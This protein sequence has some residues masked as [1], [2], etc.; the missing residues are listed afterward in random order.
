MGDTLLT[1]T[2]AFRYLGCSRY[3]T[4]KQLIDQRYVRGVWKKGRFYARPEDWLEGYNRWRAERGM[5]PRVPSGEPEVSMRE[6]AE[7]L[8]VPP[9]IMKLLI[10]EGYVQTK[11]TQVS[12][13]SAPLS[14]WRLGYAMYLRD[15]GYD[16][17][18]NLPMGDYDPLSS[19]VMTQTVFSGFAV[20]YGHPPRCTVCGKV[21]KPGVRWRWFV[22]SRL[23][24]MV[25]RGVTIPVPAIGCATGHEGTVIEVWGTRWLIGPDGS[26]PEVVKDATAEGADGEAAART[27]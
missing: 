23:Q 11:R 18:S 19:V 24:D 13:V 3:R 14:A 22:P 12:R 8:G 15:H 6:A 1:P 25:H 16:G 7:S 20:L 26:E 9:S 21:L 4:V 5:P 10:E 27:V 17:A 2:Q